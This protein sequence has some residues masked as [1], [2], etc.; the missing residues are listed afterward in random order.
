[1]KKSNYYRRVLSTLCLLCLCSCSKTT[2]EWNFW[3]NGNPNA[4]FSSGRMT[5]ASDNTTSQMELEISRTASGT[6]MYLNIFL[7]AVAPLSEDPN[8]ATFELIIEGQAPLRFYP[9]RLEGGQ[10]LLLPQEVSDYI[11]ELLLSNQCFTIKLGRNQLMVIPQ[12][13]EKNYQKLMA[14]PINA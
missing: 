12:Q 14:L 8:K 3:T 1:M 2:R 5:L 6:R 11:I 9:Y 7:L 4:C 13:F 10:R